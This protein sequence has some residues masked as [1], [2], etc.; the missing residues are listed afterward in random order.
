MSGHSK[1]A[2]IRHKKS[3]EDAKKG[4][5]FSRLSKKITA[6]AKHGGGSPDT[7]AELRAHIELAKENNMPN[8]VIDRA[9]KKGTGELEGVNYEEFS[10]EGYGPAGI[11]IYMDLMTD[12]RNRTASEIRHVFSKHGGNLGE[13]GCV[14]WMFERK[15]QITLE[16][17]D[18]TEF[19]E[20]E[21]MMAALEAGAEDVE[22]DGA[23]A[24]VYSNP[25]D[26]MSVRQNLED[27]GYH[28]TEFGVAMVASNI[29]QVN[30][31][32]DAKKILKFIDL[33]E[34]HDDVQAV[35]S[36]FDISNE[37]MEQLGD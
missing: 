24:T 17:L 4:R 23:S 18:D 3:K 11:A 1:W 37:I 15:G 35:Y 30:T 10:Y 25:S 34:E 21:V 33:V 2:N 19:D 36:N 12:N 5:V 16:S 27:A 28:I 8:D 31:V 9:I 20:D 32:E 29:V 22:V 26:T 6:A 7:N 14:A 13:S